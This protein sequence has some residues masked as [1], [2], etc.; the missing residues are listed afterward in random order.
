[1][2]K[3]S[4][5]FRHVFFSIIKIFSYPEL[6][7][8]ACSCIAVI[9]RDFFMLQ[10]TARFKKNKIVSDCGHPLDSTIP[11]DTSWVD[12]YMDFSPFWIRT[13]AF[14]LELI[15]GREK[16]RQ[17]IL[18]V[19]NFMSG[20]IELYNAAA[21]I[22]RINFSTTQRPHYYKKIKFALIHLF[23]PHLMCVPSLHVMAVLYTALHFASQLKILNIENKFNS[24]IDFA[25]K[26]AL[27]ITASILY[28]KQH[29]INCIPLAL[30]TMHSIDG[31][32]FN[33]DE[34]ERFYSSLFLEQTDF[35]APSVRSHIENL[36]KKIKN[37]GEAAKDW[38]E[39]VFAF[40]AERRLAK[41]A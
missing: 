34:I 6:W 26:H 18:L 29:S 37:E 32:F 36:Y 33:D 41:N 16:R 15:R 27:D 9:T 31:I 8:A 39:P 4:L 20:L 12:I 38:R 14:L 25:Y 5:L 2:R 22:A 17:T 19:K 3:K 13:Q 23:D 10:F 1:M 24:E 35:D 30:Y 28:V 7:R 40:L 11:F 21:S